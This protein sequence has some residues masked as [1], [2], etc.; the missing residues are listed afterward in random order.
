[1]PRRVLSPRRG[2]A[3]LARRGQRVLTHAGRPGAPWT[4]RPGRCL[5]GIGQGDSATRSQV[6]GLYA[7]FPAAVAAPSYAALGRADSSL[8]GETRT[9]L[10]RLRKRNKTASRHRGRAPVCLSSGPHRTRS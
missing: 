8:V 1:D 6:V 7:P 3:W 9:A 4:G 2:F 5:A 10:R